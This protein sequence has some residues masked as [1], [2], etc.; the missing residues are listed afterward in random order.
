MA[1]Q[2]F[3]QQPNRRFVRTLVC[4][5]HTFRLIHFD[6]S[7]AVT[8]PAY[9][10]N[11]H[12]ALFVRLILGLTS[13]DEKD[14]GLDTNVRW[15]INEDGKKGKGTITVG[16]VVYEMVAEEGPFL[17]YAICG[18]G[19]TGWTVIDPK[20]KRRVIIKKYWRAED[21]KSEADFLRVANDAGVKGV[22]RMY[23]AV[24]GETT[25]DLRVVDI[26]PQ[27]P[28]SDVVHRQETTLVL[29]A[30]G[31]AIDTFTSPTQMLGG[32]RD[33]IEGKSSLLFST[34]PFSAYHCSQP[35]ATCSLPASCIATSRTTM[36]SP[37]LM[38]SRTSPEA[39]SLTSIWRLC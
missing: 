28:R 8:S 6:R 19:T 17:R 5:E 24:E 16:N 36:S 31:G 39:C 2:I 32:L 1:R 3:I 22:C 11:K 27:P 13:H 21:R 30:Y 23:N 35:M 20:T 14:I 9:C 15:E 25:R 37:R 7:G 4:T 33:A 26:M 12:A 18:R 10:I 38:P 29:E 34:T